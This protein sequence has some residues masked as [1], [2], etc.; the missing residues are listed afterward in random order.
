VLLG[1]IAGLIVRYR[2]VVDRKNRSI[3][4]QIT[5][6]DKIEKAMERAL[7]KNMN[8]NRNVQKQ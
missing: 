2:H 5:E 4:R 8:T 1:V 6:R 7:L 3:V